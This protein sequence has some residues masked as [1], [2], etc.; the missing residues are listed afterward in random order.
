MWMSLSKQKS[1]DLQM[2]QSTLSNNSTRIFHSAIFAGK[3]ELQTQTVVEHL[4]WLQKKI[5]QMVKYLGM[6]KSD[7]V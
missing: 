2:E 7:W 1:S 3:V 6:E 5:E 4:R